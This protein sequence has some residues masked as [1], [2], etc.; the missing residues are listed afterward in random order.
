MNLSGHYWTIGPTLLGLLARRPTPR[1]TPWTATVHD[2]RHGAV[3]LTGDLREPAGATRLVIV[4]P[5][6]GGHTGSIYIRRAVRALSQRGWA[7]LVMP[8]RGA[9]LSGEGYY[10][11]ALS[12][13]LHA[14][15]G[16][17]EVRRYVQVFVL[18]FS[19]GGHVALRFATDPPPSHVRA[20]A[21]VGSPIDL[22]AAQRHFD[23][24]S[25]WLYR[26]YVLRALRKIY[27]Q[28]AA[29]GN[30][31]GPA[32]AIDS[33]RFIRDWDERAIAPRFGFRDAH[34]YYARASVAPA[35]ERL[36]VPGLLLTSRRDPMIRAVDIERAMPARAPRFTLEVHDTGGHIYFPRRFGL[37][38]RVCAWFEQA[39]AAT[40]RESA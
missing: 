36:A 26:G 37:I 12:A 35:L 3:R 16:S 10:H 7:S 15:A 5:G 27:R 34:D 24:A 8:Q 18:G 32:A 9:D 23:S 1:A 33:A 20:V 21:A 39:I 19:M 25:C 17:A 29:R 11:A 14:A 13:D 4:V 2:P 28:A 40:E 31:A 22:F 30:A 6:L 38:E